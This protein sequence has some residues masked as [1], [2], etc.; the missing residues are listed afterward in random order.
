MDNIAKDQTKIT[1]QGSNNKR[2]LSENYP[3]DK[4]EH[5]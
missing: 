3:P 2:T 5:D 4:L 1:T